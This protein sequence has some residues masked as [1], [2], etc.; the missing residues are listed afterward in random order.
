MAQE[1][2]KISLFKRVDNFV[3]TAANG[4]TFGLADYLAGAGDTAV[5]SI[6]GEEPNLKANMNRQLQQTDEAM[7]LDN[8]EGFAGLVVGSMVTGGVGFAKT[9]GI[10]ASELANGGKA[11]R[12]VGKVAELEKKIASGKK[13]GPFDNLGHADA[14]DKNSFE[15][16][17]GVVIAAGANMGING[18]I[19]HMKPKHL[20]TDGIVQEVPAHIVVWDKDQTLPATA[21]GDAN[22]GKGN[23]SITVRPTPEDAVEYANQ[24]KQ[25]GRRSVTYGMAR[26]ESLPGPGELS[27]PKK[28]TPPN[29]SGK[30]SS[31]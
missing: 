14:L 25:E 24:L 28:P 6:K 12:G 10:T 19:G 29:Q 13:L 21:Y 22:F 8:P 4:M 3:R 31:R 27:S 7:R 30:G 1:N 15:A 2:E 11:L 9:F 18:V 5:Q 16:L 20:K 23:Y 26:S 17:M